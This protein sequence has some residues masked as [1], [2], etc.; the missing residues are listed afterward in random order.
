MTTWPSRGT[1]ACRSSV[2]VMMMFTLAACGDPPARADSTVADTGSRAA[3]DTPATRSGTGTRLVFDPATVKVGDT[4]GALRVARVDVSLAADD[5]G[6][7]GNV[8]FDGQ[9]TIAGERMNHPDFPD[10][11]EICM[12][13]DSAHA[14]RLPGFPA[15]QRRRWLCFENRDDAARQLGDAGTR[16]GLTVVIDQYQTVRHFSDAYDTARLVRVVDDRRER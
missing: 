6:Y 8:R 16:G 12:S 13:V 3:P 5:M 7:V 9:I 11:K 2:V 14:D 10:V 1:R 4:L 15:D